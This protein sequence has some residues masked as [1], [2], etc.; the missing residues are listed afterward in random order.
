MTQQAPAITI[1]N[2]NKWYGDYH[3]KLRMV[4]ASLFVVR[5]GLASPL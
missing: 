4:N 1:T 5:L 2:V 3:A